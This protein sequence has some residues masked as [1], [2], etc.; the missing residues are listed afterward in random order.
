MEF[1]K[2]LWRGLFG[3]RQRKNWQQLAQEIGGEYAK[4]G[5][6]RPNLMNT[7]LKRGLVASDGVQLLYK[8]KWPIELD[9]YTVHHAGGMHG[10]SSETFTRMRAFYSR[11]DS[12]SFSIS[13][14]GLLSGLGSIFGIQD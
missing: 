2:W 14:R 3:P 11:Q 5:I 12:F 10:G 8:D 7:L 13:R 1:I 9:R 4:G 6:F